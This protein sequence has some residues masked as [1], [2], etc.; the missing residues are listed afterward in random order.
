MTMS[1]EI[2][3]RFDDMISSDLKKLAGFGWLETDVHFTEYLPDKPT[4]PQVIQ[5]YAARF[6]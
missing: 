5:N 4:V 3:K 1:P 2:A 6:L